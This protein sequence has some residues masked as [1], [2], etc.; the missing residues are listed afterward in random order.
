M[1]SKVNQQTIRTATQQDHKALANLLHF[2]TF[3]HRHLDWRQPLDWIGHNP[4]IVYEMDDEIKAAMACPPDPP[5]VAW[6]RL[7]AVEPGVSKEYAWRLLW[8]QARMELSG[9]L[10]SL[11][12]AAIPLS[13]WFTQLLV[14]SDFERTNTVIVLA[15][16]G[17]EPAPGKEMDAVTVRPMVLDDLAWVEEIDTAAF[18]GVWQN[19]QPCLE[20]AFS[21]S[22]IATVAEMDGNLVGYQI[23]T[24]SPMGG[25]LARLAVI[26]EV[27]GLG[28]GYNLVRDVLSQ[29]DRRGIHRATVNTQKDNFISLSLYKKA[30]FEPT[31]EDY[32]LYQFYP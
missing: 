24:S 9:R 7:F 25:H 6:V 20:V 32:P 12:V 3:V 22:T 21:Q 23:S 26:P 27:Q 5:N 31:G 4:F 11:H 29:F 30:G 19:S 8:D 13:S 2:G 10:G 1:I 17:K 18:G 15:W 14:S 28:I 16:R